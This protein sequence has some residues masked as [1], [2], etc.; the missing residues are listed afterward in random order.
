MTIPLTDP[1]LLKRFYAPNSANAGPVMFPIAKTTKIIALVAMFAFVVL[2]R[3]IN[4]TLLIVLRHN[5]NLYVASDS[6]LS[7]L[8]GKKPE[9]Y[10]KCFP[11]SET[12]CVCISGFG[13]ASGTIC[14]TSNHISFDFRFPQQ[15][16][17]IARQ[18][19]ARHRPFSENVT[20]I[21]NHF[22]FIY[23]SLMDLLVTNNVTN[24]ESLDKTDVY[25]IG[26]DTSSRSFCQISSHFRPLSP[27]GVVLE[28]V[29]IPMSSMGFMGEYGFLSALIRNDDPRLKALRTK[30]LGAALSPPL[31]IKPEL[32]TKAVCGGILQ[33]YALHNK[34]SKLFNYDA[35]LV[36]P[37]YV[38]YK[39][40]TNNVICAYYGSSLAKPDEIF[41]FILISFVVLF[42]VVAAI[43]I[44]FQT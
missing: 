7:D 11:A 42:V 32:E 30:A 17:Q 24:V 31:S 41:L 29:P 16:Q 2:P 10:L 38:I 27:Y 1:F 40:S 21:L 8:H 6:V 44:A 14:T 19:F 12:S 18:E 39:I 4:A 20:N 43:K 5:N 13:G 25:F 23:R 15:L 3:S 37:P 35:G 33:L 34:Y 26:Y 22:E 9:K 36:G 28:R